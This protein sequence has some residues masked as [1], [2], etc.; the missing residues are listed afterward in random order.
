MPSILYQKHNGIATITMNRPEKHNAMNAQMLVELSRAW[1]DFRDDIDMRVAVLTGAGDR[2][3]CAGA[4]LGSLLPLLTRS[5]S[6]QDEWD[7]ELLAD[8]SIQMRAVLRGF[9]LYK[10]VIAAINGFA[11]AGG[12][13]I[14]GACDLR[15]AAPQAT[16]GLTE[17]KRGLAPGG[18]SM[19]RLA[20]QIPLAKAMEIL[21]TGEPMSAEEAHRI[22]LVNEITTADGLQKRAHDIARLVAD[23]AP[24]AVQACKE[25]VLRTSGLRYE[26]AYK[27]E[28]EVALRVLRSKDAVEGPK[29]FIEKRTPKFTST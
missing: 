1:L 22:G 11:L 28:D 12:S 29:A 2:A 20:R 10:P 16:L 21:L 7:E 14:L 8:K 19:V 3:F 9:D 17:V 24:L 4:D 15:I 13:E 6:A 27:I 5:R 18:G 23:N 26:D 25:V